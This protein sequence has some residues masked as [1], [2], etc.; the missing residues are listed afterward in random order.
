MAAKRA[1][2]LNPYDMGARGVLGVCHLVCGEHRHAIELF[3]TAAQQA[4][5]IP[6]TNGP[7]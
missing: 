5:T 7:R 6:G 1:V 4:A 3:T 2:G